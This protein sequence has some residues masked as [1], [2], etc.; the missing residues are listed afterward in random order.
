MP[1]ILPQTRVLLVC[2]LLF[3]FPCFFVQAGTP[4]TFPDPGLQ[5]AV[6]DAIGKTTTELTLEDLSSPFF[7]LLPGESRKIRNL[8]GI[9]K[10][11]SLIEVVL[12]D[13]EIEDLRPISKMTWLRSLSIDK[14]QIRDLTPLSSLIHLE[15]LWISDNEVSNLSPLRSLFELKVLNAEHNMITSMDD[16]QGLP[17]MKHL[18]LAR[19]RANDLILHL[20]ENPPPPDT[21]NRNMDMDLFPPS[22]PG[23]S[24]TWEFT[25]EKDAGF[26][27]D[28]SSEASVEYIIAGCIWAY[29]LKGCKVRM[30]CPISEFP[31]SSQNLD[32][33]FMT[34]LFKSIGYPD[35]PSPRKYSVLGGEFYYSK[36]LAQIIDFSLGKQ[37]VTGISTKIEFL[38]HAQ[39]APG[40][41]E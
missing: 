7:T 19:N 11:T 28:V 15:D 41:E 14:N 39:L 2:L 22:V 9:E 33:R 26:V 12:S 3:V 8:E 35:C 23:F 29:G 6:A 16:L 24:D 37:A 34:P 18:W 17:D 13:N 25:P 10:C 36:R 1:L 38:Y 31:L 21:R 40:W 20:Q 4:Y 30:A 5:A 32:H 27:V